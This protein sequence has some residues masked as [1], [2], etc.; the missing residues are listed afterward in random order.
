VKYL[1]VYAVE[2]DALN[3]S[4]KEFYERYGFVSLLANPR[5]KYLPMKQIVDLGLSLPANRADL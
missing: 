5:H 1:A 2:V 3:D 4:A